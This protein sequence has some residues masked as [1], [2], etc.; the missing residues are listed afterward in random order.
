[1][2][3]VFFVVKWLLRTRWRH[4]MNYRI[5]FIAFL[6]LLLSPIATSAAQPQSDQTARLPRSVAN[7]LIANVNDAI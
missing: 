4:P 6:A 1:M 7:C 3:F 5:L 2:F